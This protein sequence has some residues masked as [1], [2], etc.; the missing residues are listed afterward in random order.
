[1]F[2]LDEIERHEKIKVFD[3]P[4]GKGARIWRYTCPAAPMRLTLANGELT[5]DSGPLTGNHPDTSTGFSTDEV[6]LRAAK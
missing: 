4:D 2:K 1:M 5:F 3:V 6:L